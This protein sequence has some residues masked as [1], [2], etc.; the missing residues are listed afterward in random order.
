MFLIK[1]DILQIIIMKEGFC[2]FQNNKEDKNYYL[3]LN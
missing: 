1:S 2:N 3:L